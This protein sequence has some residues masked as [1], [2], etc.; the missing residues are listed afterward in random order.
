MCVNLGARLDLEVFRFSL[1]ASWW[2]EGLRALK[3]R[4][5]DLSPP[6]RSNPAT[7]KSACEGDGQGPDQ[8]ER[9]QGLGLGWVYHFLELDEERADL[10]RSTIQSLSV[11]RSSLVSRPAFQF[12][13]SVRNPKNSLTSIPPVFLLSPNLTATKIGA[14]LLRT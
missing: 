13:I 2:V 12:G 5:R 6:R 11:W 4:V 3:W 7:G 14:S 1:G 8:G 10:E 9:A